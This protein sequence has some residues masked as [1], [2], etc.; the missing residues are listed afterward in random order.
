MIVKDKV[1]CSLCLT[2]FNGDKI[3]A[4]N[5]QVIATAIMC[6]L[7]QMTINGIIT[8]N[9]KAT[10][11]IAPCNDSMALEITVKGGE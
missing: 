5:N 4:T 2:D 9:F 7:G 11:D 6:A 8:S 1:N 3:Y 10:I